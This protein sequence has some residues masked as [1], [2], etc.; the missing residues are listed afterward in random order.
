MRWCHLT[1]FAKCPM[2][3][4]KVHSPCYTCTW[5]IRMTRAVYFGNDPLACWRP[6]EIWRGPAKVTW[7]LGRQHG[8]RGEYFLRVI[9][10]PCSFFG[11]SPYSVSFPVSLDSPVPVPVRIDYSSK[12]RLI[13]RRPHARWGKGW[14]EYSHATGMCRSTGYGF[15]LSLSLELNGGL[16]ISVSVWNRVYFLPFRLWNTVGVT[17]FLPESRHKRTRGGSVA[18]PARVP[19]YVH[20]N[21]PFPIRTAFHVFQSGTGY[22]FSRFCLKQGSKIASLSFWTGSQALSGTPPS[23]GASCYIENVFTISI[24]TGKE[25]WMQGGPVDILWDQT[26]TVYSAKNVFPFKSE[27]V[28]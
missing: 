28:N 8:S 6:R 24:S 14:G 19:L 10:V 5:L 15:C 13:L 18:V 7:A 23:P 25:E 9:S 11:L 3:W 1:D 17:I 21:T 26:S 12:W 16:Q 20:S 27:H 22:L 4:A 2:E